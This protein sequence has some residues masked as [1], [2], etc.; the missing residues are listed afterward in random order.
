MKTQ[1]III[2]LVLAC[3]L[4]GAMGQIFFKLSSENFSFNPFNLIKN[5]KFLIGASLYAISAIFFVWALKFGDVSTLYPIIATSYIWVGLFA[6]IFL[7]EPF[8]LI[9]LGGITLIIIGIFLIVK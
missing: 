9:R 2:L 4:L 3:A 5:Y 6:N 1:P 8:P 7:K